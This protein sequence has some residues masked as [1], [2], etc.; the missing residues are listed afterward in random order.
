MTSQAGIRSG[1][2]RKKLIHNTEEAAYLQHVLNSCSEH[3][4]GCDCCGWRLRCM[5]YYDWWC[6]DGKADDA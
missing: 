2:H 3:N 6:G 1:Y 4:G 5:R